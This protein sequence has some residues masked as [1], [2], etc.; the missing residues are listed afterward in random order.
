MKPIHD[1]MPEVH[2]AQDYPIWLDR[3][4]KD[5]AALQDLLRPCAP[6]VLKA[7]PVSI[8][9]NIPRNESPKCP[10]RAG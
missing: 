7:Y 2:S 9:A 1:R 8:L 10:E 5:K 4:F 6:N 3:E